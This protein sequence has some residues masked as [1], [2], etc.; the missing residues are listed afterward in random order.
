MNTLWILTDSSIFFDEVENE[1]KECAEH[2]VF[3][4]FYVA[5]L[6]IT[7]IAIPFSFNHLIA[8]LI[9]ALALN[10]LP[11]VFYRSSK[12]LAKSQIEKIKKDP[13][14]PH[15]IIDDFFIWKEGDRI[16]SRHFNGRFQ[17][18]DDKNRIVLSGYG[19]DKDLSCIPPAYFERTSYVTNKDL[20]KRKK[21]RARKRIKKGVKEVTPYDELRKEFRKE[22]KKLKN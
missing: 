13:R 10:S 22:Y 8:Y 19:Y 7:L 20:K 1:I 17:G 9:G 18:V 2:E 12:Y 16:E 3:L 11:Y 15:E 6:V 14:L 4:I 21:K 5:T